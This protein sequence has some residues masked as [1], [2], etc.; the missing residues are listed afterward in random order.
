[1]GKSTIGR[2]IMEDY[3]ADVSSYWLNRLGAPYETIPAS[4]R[5]NPLARVD[6]LRE[7]ASWA[8]RTKPAEPGAAYK[9]GQQT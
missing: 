8:V 6:A 5:P 1:V 7:E 9:A 2:D 4:G 3:S